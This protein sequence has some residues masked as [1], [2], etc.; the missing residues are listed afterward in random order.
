MI[1]WPHSAAPSASFARL[2]RGS[3]RGETTTRDD[4]LEAWPYHRK[5][6]KNKFKINYQ[7]A[8]QERKKRKLCNVILG[9][10]FSFIVKLNVLYSKM[11]SSPSPFFLPLK[12]RTKVKYNVVKTRVPPR[13]KHYLHSWP[14][15]V[16]HRLCLGQWKKRIWQQTAAVASIRQSVRWKCEK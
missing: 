8:Y 14:I 10:S 9:L 3:S 16:Q 6:K 13:S 4:W 12:L 11:S 2:Q 1:V 15:T 7:F 5:L